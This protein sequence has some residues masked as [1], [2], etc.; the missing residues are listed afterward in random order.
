MKVSRPAGLA[1]LSAA[2]FLSAI[3][4]AFPAGAQMNQ[5]VMMKWMD[6][7]VVHYAVTGDYEGEVLV[8][9]AGTNGIATV[10][11]HVRIDFDYDVGNGRLVGTPTYTDAVTEVGP[12]RNG[13][14]GCRPPT[15]SGPFEYSTIESLADGYGGQLMMKVRRDYPAAQMTV[16]CTGGNESV[17]GRSTS[18][19]TEL[20]VP[21]IM[22]LAMGAALT[23]DELRVST[24]GSSFI[25][26]KDG[27]TYTYVPTKVK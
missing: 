10:K 16:A 21:G 14:D 4:A 11:D 12:I 23:G 25:V 24:D 6:A 9:D 18:E 1:H 27:W 5:E 22:M 26:K 20:G 7:T 15:L 17:A 2:G 19:D 8:V 3:L 13:A